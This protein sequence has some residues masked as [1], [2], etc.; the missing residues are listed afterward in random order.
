ME[1]LENAPQHISLTPAQRV[2]ANNLLTLPFSQELH[3]QRPAQPLTDAWRH[4]PIEPR[5]ATLLGIS[6]RPPH[7]ETLGLDSRSTLQ[8][9]LDYPFQ[10]IRLGAYWKRIEPEP[11]VFHLDE[12]DW[13]IAAAER[14]GKQIILCIGPL[15]TFSYPEFFVPAH[16]LKHPFPEH[17]L[18]KPSAYPALLEA[19]SAFI[20]RIV[21]RYKQR[22]SIVAWQLEHE[23]VDPLGV[24][25]S[26]RLDVTFVEKEV[27]AL[28]QA[29]PDRPI[30]MNGFLPSSLLVSLSQRWQTRDQGDSLAI[31]QRFADI[32]GLDYYPRH[33]LLSLGSRTLYLDGAKSSWQQ[34]R[35]KQLSPL[36]QAHRQKLMVAEGQAE[37][38]ET[39]TTPPNPA[40]S[41]MYS[42]PP[43]QLIANYNACMR[44][45]LQSMPL[46]A[47][48][49]WGAEYWMLRKQSADPS[50]LQ[51]FARLLEES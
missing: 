37:P 44:W 3:I 36:L 19:A 29:D 33:A 14:A 28:R 5:R 12:L 47:Y 18:I 30:M 49:F 20:A 45:S 46:Y 41:V 17:T 4:L 50:Y 15:K 24:E 13:Q 11:G 6:F 42:C 9:L 8:T 51:A 38:W 48:L 2:G 39:V 35:L 27:E 21:E 26:W 1:K 40:G 34:H 43:E 23:A 7:I 22:A 16:H 10:L 32:V 31:A 25:H